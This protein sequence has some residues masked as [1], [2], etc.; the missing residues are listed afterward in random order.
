MIL[1]KQVDVLFR[2][3]GLLAYSRTVY[4]AVCVLSTLVLAVLFQHLTDYLDKRVFK[5]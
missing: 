5:K 4:F 2:H 3:L 1:P